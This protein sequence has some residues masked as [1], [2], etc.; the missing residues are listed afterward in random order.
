ARGRA[1]AG[2]SVEE[3]GLLAVGQLRLRGGHDVAPDDAVE[4]RPYRLA[5]VVGLDV[6]VGLE[7]EGPLAARRMAAP[8][9]VEDRVDGAGDFALRER[10]LRDVAALVT[11]AR[12][13]DGGLVGGAVAADAGG[14]EIG[15]TGDE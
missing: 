2:P 5:E 1:L 14:L 7:R 11:L 12:R 4:A 3:G 13:R 15:I 9:V 6:G 10:R 8:A